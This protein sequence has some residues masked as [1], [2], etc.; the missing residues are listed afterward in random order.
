MPSQ[1]VVPSSLRPEKLDDYIGQD[2]TKEVLRVAIQAA[3]IKKEALDHTII[4]GP[5][6]L[7]KTT[8]AR[9]IANEMGWSIKTTIGGSLKTPKSVET[10]FRVLDDNSIVFVDEIHRVQK[11]AQEVFYPVMED[12]VIY[13]SFAG[14]SFS[15]NLG[16]LTIIG[17]TTAI[18]KLAQP[19]LDRFGLSF[20]LEYYTDEEMATL[21]KTNSDKLEMSLSN[22]AIHEVVTRA[23]KTPRIGN[24]ILKRIQDFKLAWNLDWSEIDGKWVAKLLWDKFRI[25]DD[26]LLG[27]DRKILRII[28]TRGP[29]GVDTI[30]SIANESTETI[31]GM[32]EPYLLALGYI[33]RDRDGRVITEEGKNHLALLRK[34]KDS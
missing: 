4:N 3:K 7:G 26:G 22:S 21:V 24:R 17:A 8:L 10:L 2:R 13:T 28:A 11:P 12:N 25:D 14:T 1:I 30:G 6:G 20:Q 16:P 23:R 29:V 5:P 27:I 33:N 34:V 19:F 32:V 31:E 15:V 9:I 18:G